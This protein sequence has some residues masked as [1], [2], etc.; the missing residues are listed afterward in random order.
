MGPI[1]IIPNLIATF[2]G[3]PVPFVRGRP[4]LVSVLVAGVAAALIYGLP[5]E[6]GLII[7]AL[8]GGIAAVIAEAARPQHDRELVEPS[9]HGSRSERG[10]H[11]RR[12]GPRDFH[13]TLS[14]A[15]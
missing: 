9:A 8:L 13:D 7:A 14:G 15:G 3:M 5:N 6:L 12:D 1:A 10:N 4:A 11:Y 2:I